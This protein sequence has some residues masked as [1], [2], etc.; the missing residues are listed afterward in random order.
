M[1]NKFTINTS[2]SKSILL[3]R[4]VLQESLLLQELIKLETTEI[5]LTISHNHIE[6]IYEYMK[7]SSIHEFYITDIPKP[8]VFSVGTYLKDE[9]YDEFFSG[10]TY[11]DLQ[12]LYT[13]SD[14][15]G[16]TILCKL[17][18]AHISFMLNTG[19]IYSVDIPVHSVST[20]NVYN[21]NNGVFEHM[22]PEYLRTYLDNEKCKWN[23][24]R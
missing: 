11:V 3:L 4:M 10:Y 23:I 5:T 12:Q 14:Y 8:C 9:W 24:V 15:L 6:R 13:S 21:I 17:I 20:R 19:L 18:V 16:M 22:S 1:N 2:D 7:Y